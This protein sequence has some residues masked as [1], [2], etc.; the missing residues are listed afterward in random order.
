MSTTV[1]IKKYD[2]TY[3]TPKLFETLVVRDG[4]VIE[5]TNHLTTEEQAQDV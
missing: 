3:E 2:H 4:V 5:K 1:T